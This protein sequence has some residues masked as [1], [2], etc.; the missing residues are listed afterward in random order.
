MKRWIALLMVI[1]MA[2][3]AF[4]ASAGQ[5][6]TQVTGPRGPELPSTFEVVEEEGLSQSDTSTSHTEASIG[7]DVY[8]FVDPSTASYVTFYVYDEWDQ[9]LANATIEIS[10]N[11]V[12]AVYGVTDDNGLCSMYLFRNVEYEYHVTCY[13]YEHDGGF[14]TP[15][16]E[17]KRIEI[18][19]RRHHDF[20]VII[21]KNGIP[22]PN[23][24]VWIDG[25]Y[26]VTDEH[27]RVETWVYTG[28]HTVK[29]RTSNG[30]YIIRKVYVEWDVFVVI[31]LAEYVVDRPVEP[32]GEDFLV[33]NKL[34]QPED[35][36][37]TYLLRRTRDVLK[38]SGEDDEA[39]RQRAQE[40]IARY[41]ST[42]LVE[43][44]PERVQLFPGKDQDVLGSDGTPRY[45]RRSMMPDGALLRQWEQEYQTVI[46]TNEQ[47]GL[48]FDLAD[49]HSEA[50]SKVF[51][52]AS[53]LAQDGSADPVLIDG[54]QLE[55]DDPS[56]ICAAQ[57]DLSLIRPFRFVFDAENGPAD[58]ELLDDEVFDGTLFEFRIT[59]I[60]KKDAAGQLA[61]A[62]EEQPEHSGEVIAMANEAF[63]KNR[64]QRLMA[65][66]LLTDAESAALLE[67]FAGGA[68]AENLDVQAL[69]D[70]AVDGKMYRVSCWLLYDGVEVDVTSLMDSL[71]AVWNA[72]DAV[73][74]LMKANDGDEAAALQALEDRQMQ[75]MDFAGSLDVHAQGLQALRTMPGRDEDFFS[76]LNR[77]RYTQLIVDVRTVNGEYRSYTADAAASQPDEVCAYGSVPYAGIAWIAPEKQDE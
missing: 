69:T 35:Y 42:V 73:K 63:E 16:G 11:G 65:D 9:P 4:G 1:A 7:T 19:L 66:G 10:Y 33:Y 67:N 45:A 53:V 36:V 54:A 20:T 71:Q 43:A 76:E 44:Q 50:M 49:L 59:P 68:P 30:K 74:A 39:Y 26:F 37:L 62:L 8:L 18:R 47:I 29:V 28:T 57:L 61:S 51:A 77:K 3:T 52:L 5:Q 41:P 25:K 13:H 6:Y 40:Y 21:N 46:F 14:F 32:Y 58:V 17:T 64:Q 22:M 23:T 48:R 31:D 2:L 12:K 75:V 38:L 27:G 56:A 72:E 55:V 24:P 70:A 34:Y 15:T 60:E